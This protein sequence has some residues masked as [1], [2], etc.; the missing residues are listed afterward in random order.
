M[1][2][3]KNIA[4]TN[5]DASVMEKTIHPSDAANP[6]QHPPNVLSVK[7]VKSIMIFNISVSPSQ[8]NMVI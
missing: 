2:T 1:A 5:Q 6:I 4:H 8:K 7:V 3:Q